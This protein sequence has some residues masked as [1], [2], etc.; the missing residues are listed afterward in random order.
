M[1]TYRN[2]LIKSI[3]SI[4][5]DMCGEN[6][7]QE[8]LGHEYALLEAQWGYNSKQDGKRYDIHLC[9]QCFMDIVIFIKKQRKTNLGPF[10]YAY[11]YD[12]LEGIQS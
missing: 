4:Y 5:C 3:D 10:K 8:Q 9:E 2:K 11:K 12:P 6:C 7:T 1:K